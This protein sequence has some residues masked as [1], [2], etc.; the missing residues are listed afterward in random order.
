MVLI[1]PTEAGSVP[2]K[3]L[4]S[5]YACTSAGNFCGVNTSGKVPESLQKFCAGALF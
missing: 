1:E 2:L 3:P 4:P 5:Q